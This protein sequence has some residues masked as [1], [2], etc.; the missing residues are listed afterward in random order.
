MLGPD[1]LVIDGLFSDRAEIATSIQRIRVCNP[2][3]K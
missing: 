3:D 1:D 2:N